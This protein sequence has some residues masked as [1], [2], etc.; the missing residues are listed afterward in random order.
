MHEL[1]S[2]GQVF[3]IYSYCCYKHLMK[4]RPMLFKHFYHIFIGIDNVCYLCRRGVKET[5][6]QIWKVH[7][8]GC[9]PVK[10]AA[11][12][13]LGQVSMRCLCIPKEKLSQVSS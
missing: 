8:C 4:A 11:L 3:H 6:E 9:V 12:G 5:H 10:D 13:I 1:K 2:R 7:I